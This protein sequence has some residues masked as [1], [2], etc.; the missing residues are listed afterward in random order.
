MVKKETKESEEQP[1]N[2]DLP[3]TAV[4]KRH[5]AE[6]VLQNRIIIHRGIGENFSQR[7]SVCPMRWFRITLRHFLHFSP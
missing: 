2:S 4:Q 6:T 7:P 3:S 5:L 1:L